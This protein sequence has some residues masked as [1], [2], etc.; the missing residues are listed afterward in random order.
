MTELH[1]TRSKTGAAKMPVTSLEM[2]GARS[3]AALGE[4]CEILFHVH[5]CHSLAEHSAI[6]IVF[7]QIMESAFKKQK[8][9][10]PR[11]VPNCYFSVIICAST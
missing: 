7:C 8:Q 4:F 5:F 10:K 11:S 1:D 3:L 6:A 2:G 9:K